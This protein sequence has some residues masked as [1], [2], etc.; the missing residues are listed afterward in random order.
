MRERRSQNERL[1]RASIS[2][3]TKPRRGG[4]ALLSTLSLLA[5]AQAIPAKAGAAALQAGG[6]PVPGGGT[7]TGHVTAS[8]GGK[9]VPGLT[10][11]LRE[12]DQTTTTGADGFYNFSN[13]A[14]GTYTVVLI[15]ASGAE[16]ETRVSVGTG[17]TAVGDIVTDVTA[18]ALDEIIVTAQRTPVHL[19]RSAQRIAPNLVN[20]QT[21]TEIRKLPDVSV[22]EAVRRVPGV[23]LETDEGEG[24]Y[25]NIRGLDADLNST[26]FGGLRLPPTNNASPF[27]GYRA[28]TLDS[29]PIGLVGAI[30]VTKSNT[31]SM[32]AEALGGTIE[33]TPKTAPPGGQPFI[34]GNVGSGFEPLS[35][36]YIADFAAT[37]GGHFG[38]PNGFFSPGPFSIVVTGSY[39]E[40]SRGFYDAEPAYFNDPVGAA[41]SRPYTA[42]GNIDQRDY[43]LNRK[44]HSFGVD[45]GYEPNPQNSW[46]VR[47]FDA[48]YAER[49]T[50]PRLSISPDG[51]A[52]QLA[53]GQIQDTLVGPPNGDGTFGSSIVNQLRDEFESSRDR[54]LTAGGRNIFGANGE[55]TIDYRVGYTQ[56]DYKKPY[57][58][59]ST[60]SINPAATANGTIAY[61]NSGPGHLP[62]YSIAN[63]P[64]LDP[65]QYTLTGITNS[66]AYNYDLEFSFAANYTRLLDVFGSNNGN[67]KLGGSVRL[68][69]KQTNA[70][71]YSV[72]NLP[73]PG[74]SLV[75]YAA[76]PNNAYYNGLYQNGYS[77]RPGLLQKAFGL[78]TIDATPGTANNVVGSQ[79][80]FLNAHEDVYA[81]YAQYQADFGRLHAL[82]GVRVENTADS[83]DAFST[84]TTAATPTTPAVVSTLPVKGH[85]NYTNVFPSAQFKYEIMHDMLAR[86]AYS[87]S[88]ARPGFNQ[89]VP[90]LSVDLGSNTVTQGN[91]NLKPATANNFDLSIEKYLR[92]AGII[93]VGLFYKDFT[94]YIVPRSL[95]L[96]TLPPI[97]GFNYNGGTLK[98]F[99]FV[100]ARSSYA[101]GVELN[102]DHR[103]RKLP[104]LLSGLG[105]SANFTYVDSR[106]EIRPGEFSKL[107]STSAYTYN[108][109][110]FYEK[111]PVALRLAAYSASA[112]LF[113]IGSSQSTDIYNATRTSMDFGASYKLG[114]HWT[115]YFNAKN[116]LNTPH[117]FYQGT[118]DRPI[119]REFYNESYQLGLRFEY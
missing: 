71:P 22:A 11:R 81:G 103:F 41:G 29:I 92:G 118:P 109:A 59:N 82:A 39:Y 105:L 55:N 87:T 83:S 4:I 27:G 31:P 33:I 111:G 16:A 102:F 70:Q 119:Q 117:A 106:F 76:R 108:A 93:S 84:I 45:L 10:V 21:Y 69:K 49:Y 57:D 90:S 77:I 37:A 116:L 5:L 25:V 58:Y 65:T 67:F 85:A 51:N 13:I 60:F 50:R 97:P 101:R 115:S 52:V 89:A 86:F 26:T 75:D 88:L 113:G 35:G 24:R 110:V 61:A 42:I 66:T 73:N 36:T 54:I 20:I 104:G 34:Q 6:T 53:N 28:V 99:T 78:G 17:A 15:K 62:V 79:Q 8:R 12:T 9:P 114:K 64:Y 94:D 30:T 68:R 100:N 2:P 18:T 44:R 72:F 96:A 23:S 47:A 91:P 1:L 43:T 3:D 95:D 32:D 74:P 63:V 40:D 46:Y 7:I 98:S 14:P 38:G 56:G 112:D 107:P 19:A 80:Q 48:G